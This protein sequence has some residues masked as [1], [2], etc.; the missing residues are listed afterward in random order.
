MALTCNVGG[1]DKVFRIALGL[2]LI[3]VVLFVDMATVWKVVAGV[4]A[5]I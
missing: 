2:A 1:G 3:A 4:A 5:A